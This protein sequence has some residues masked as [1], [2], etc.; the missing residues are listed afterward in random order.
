M[1]MLALEFAWKLISGELWNIYQ[2]HK[3]KHAAQAVANAPVTEEELEDDLK[4]HRL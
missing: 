2:A 3:A 4:N 1:L